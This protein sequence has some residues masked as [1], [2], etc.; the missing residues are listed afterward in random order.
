[1]TRSGLNFLM[2]HQPVLPSTP[3]RQF[4]PPGAEVLLLQKAGLSCEGR[5][6]GEDA[7][8]QHRTVIIVMRFLAFSLI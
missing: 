2:F 8:G 6:G 3:W 7:P 5:D 1:V 4:S